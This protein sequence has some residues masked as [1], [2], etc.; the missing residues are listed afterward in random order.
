MAAH[1]WQ[2]IRDAGGSTYYVAGDMVVWSFRG[3]NVAVGY[4]ERAGWITPDAVVCMDLPTMAVARELAE[5]MAD[6]RLNLQPHAN[7]Q[8]DS[9]VV[10]SRAWGG[11]APVYR[12]T[13]SCSCGATGTCDGKRDGIVE[14]AEHLREL[15]SSGAGAAEWGEAGEAFRDARRYGDA[16]RPMQVAGD[17]S[18]VSS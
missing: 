4:D 12:S 6:G 1:D 8:V 9:R 14:R 10:G 5:A 17:G 11:Y 3:W 18:Q 15:V 7:V 13:W 2:R 16:V